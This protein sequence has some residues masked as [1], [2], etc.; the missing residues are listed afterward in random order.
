[1]NKKASIKKGRVFSGECGKL[2]DKNR[3]KDFLEAVIPSGSRVCLEGDNQKQAD[4]LA[5]AM[6]SLDPSKVNRLHMVQ[7]SVV[8]P[9]HLDMFE[10]G[11]AEKLDFAFSGPQA[12]RLYR[13][14]DE[15]KIKIGAIHT[16]LELYARYFSDLTP[17]IALVVADYADKDGNLYT[18]YNTEDTP[19]ICEA[20]AFGGG[21]VIAQVKEIKEKLPRVDIPGD[22]VNF[23]VPTGEDYYI[24]PLFTRDPAKISRLQILLGMM[25]I[26]G[27][28]EKYR[29]DSLNHGIG[30]NS[31]AIELLLP[32]Y[33]KHLKG[34]I[35]RYW[36]LNPHPTLIPAIESG[37][38]KSVYSFGG[39]PG[40]EDYVKKHK[41]LFFMGPDGNMRSGRLNAQL[42]GLYGIDCFLG[43]TL[44]IDKYGNS[45]TA[46]KGMISGFG[47]APNLGST[48]PG[49]RHSTASWK[50]T[51]RENKSFFKATGFKKGQKLV[52]QMTPTFSEKKH[53]PVFVDELDAVTLYK[54]GKFD[55][56]PVMIYADNVTHIVTE[57][58]IANLLKCANRKERARAIE[59]VAGD[60]P[61]GKRAK[62]ENTAK[63]RKKGIV[64]TCEDLGIDPI[65]AKRSLLA[66]QSLEDIVKISNNLYKIPD[67]FKKTYG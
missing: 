36:A 35:C 12:K 47:G 11:I 13:L 25:V 26:K 60:T 59:A 18:G 30:Y 52:V 54:E 32:T 55:S 67:R 37:F 16:Y 38:V 28:Y 19:V 49:R 1:M 56:P 20:A 42:M 58:G 65:D 40:M 63:L 15:K 8:L 41:S 3:I 4:F 31:A 48:P 44:Q 66:A 10:K 34:K 9:E 39:E 29:V 27:I 57:C 22:W 64:S 51:A 33:A 17:D 62:P 50:K 53:I 7:S 21:I 43:S 46:V 23:V 14:V 61:V 24:Q 45:S 5:R 2:I 6:S